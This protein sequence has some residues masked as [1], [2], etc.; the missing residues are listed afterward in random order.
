[1]A[2]GISISQECLNFIKENLSKESTILEFGS[3]DGTVW[4]SKLGFTIYSVENQMEWMDRFPSATNYINCRS[5]YYGKDYP[6]PEGIR[7]RRGWYYLEDILSKI[8]KSYDLILVDGP[9]SSWGR[10]G[11]YKHINEFNTDVTMIFDDIHRVQDA[12]VMKSV[13]EH[14]GRGYELIDKYTGVI[15]AKS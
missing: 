5:R 10:G 6:A 4:L 3:G 7:E 14:V 8:P 15:R 12:D 13:S 9:G 11:F 2:Q 1:M